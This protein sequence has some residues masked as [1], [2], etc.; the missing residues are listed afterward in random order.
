MNW[1]Y[2]WKEITEKEDVISKLNECGF[3]GWEVC[4]YQIFTREQFM[5][6]YLGTGENVIHPY[7]VVR[8]LLKKRADGDNQ[9]R[10]V[11]I[12]AFEEYS[13]IHFPAE[14][15]TPHWSIQGIVDFIRLFDEPSF[16]QN[17]KQ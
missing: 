2:E 3:L 8:V 9:C 7:T 1:I 14:R 12:K 10:E 17:F 11:I 4:Y 5:N 15:E 6:N 16:A 13:K